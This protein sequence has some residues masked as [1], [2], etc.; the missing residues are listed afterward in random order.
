MGIVAAWYRK[1]PW[2]YLLWPLSLLYCVLAASRRKRLERARVN[3]PVR[4]PVIVIGNIS[5]GGTGKT[6]LLILLART[7]LARG[8][9]VGIVSRGYGG[10]REHSPCEVTAHSAVDEVGD[11]AV[12]IRRSVACPMFVDTLRTRAVD[13]LV[14]HYG[15]E[16][17]LS[18][19]GLQ[20]YALARARE[21]VVL[22]GTRMFGNG[23][24]LPAGPLREPI[25]RLQE[26]DYLLV[27]GGDAASWQ[28][29]LPLLPER[30]QAQQMTLQPAAW[31][32]L[33]TGRRL[34][35]NA[36]PLPENARLYALAGIGN[37]TRFFDTLRALGYAPQCHPFPDHHRFS[38]QDVA[39]AGDDCLVMTHKDAVKCAAWVGANAWYLEVEAQLDANFL[40]QLCNDMQSLLTPAVA[41]DDHKRD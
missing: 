28:A 17:I 29:D 21:L 19:D 22:D 34:P 32:Q 3:A 5:V 6:P 10:K 4:P 36:L 39:F 9:R 41:D 1:S 31:V 40:L 18:D 12:L 2:L 20:H 35:L 13:A 23:L 7:L 37:P 15:C 14:S 27:N 16:L 33:Q 26:V 30:L 25:K 24:C 8:V 38:A 11:E